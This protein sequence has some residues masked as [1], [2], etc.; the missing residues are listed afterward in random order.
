MWSSARFQ[1]YLRQRGRGSLWGGLIYPSMQ[2]AV[3]GAL[4][5]AQ[6]RV[7]PRG[8]SF[9]LYGADFV[10]GRDFRPWLIEINAS[11]TMRAS[12]PVTA[13]LCARVLEDTIKV[14]LDR[15]ADRGCDVGSFE[16]LGRQ[17]RG[18]GPGAG[19][20]PGPARL[21]PRPTSGPTGHRAQAEHGVP[22]QGLTQPSQHHSQPC[23][24]CSPPTSRP[25]T[26]LA[27]AL[28][29]SGLSAPSGSAVSSCSEWALCPP[30]SV[31][32]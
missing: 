32:F 25:P 4:T 26:W 17:V 11:P 18:V 10:L 19:G 7:E 9:E 2:R 3:A 31:S 12:T 16:L 24:L 30:P 27:M 28:G 29:P 5:A 21:W 1:E 14:V 6:G 23:S 13:R 22:A 15:R 8:N 20:G